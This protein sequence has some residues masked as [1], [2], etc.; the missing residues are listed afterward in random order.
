MLEKM[1]EKIKDFLYN[2]SDLM[3]ALLIIAVAAYIIAWKVGDILSYPEQAIS[4]IKTEENI[5][6]F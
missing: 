6:K 5:E 1:I 3:V 4:Q 2:I